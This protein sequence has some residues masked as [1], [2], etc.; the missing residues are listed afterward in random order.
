MHGKVVIGV[1]NQQPLEGDSETA[2]QYAES[3]GPEKG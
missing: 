2:E 3:R 1:S